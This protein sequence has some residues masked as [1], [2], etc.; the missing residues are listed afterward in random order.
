MPPEE[1][2]A[3]PAKLPLERRLRI[4]ARTERFPLSIIVL[5]VGAFLSILALAAFTPL[6]NSGPFPAIQS[7]TEPTNGPN[8]NLLFI[9]VGPIV[10]MVGA[11]LVGAYYVARHRFEHLML[12]RSKA[13]FLR[14]LPE[15][16]DL[17]WELTP[18]DEVRYQ[19]KKSELRIRR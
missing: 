4:F 5:A 11:Y 8:Y 7:A 14:N 2:P 17:L 6:G 10:A 16:E 9:V 3:V 19:D 13:E 15:V 18:E 1:T 12:S